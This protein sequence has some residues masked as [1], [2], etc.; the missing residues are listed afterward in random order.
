MGCHGML[1]SRKEIAKRMGAGIQFAWLGI[2]GLFALGCSIFVICMVVYVIGA[3]IYLCYQAIGF[4]LV[5]IPF[6]VLGVLYFLYWLGDFGT[7]HHWGETEAQ[8][9][10]RERFEK[11]AA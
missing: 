11:A 5:L 2:L 7:R 4:W 3:F 9:E 1:P 8:K 10:R 6:G